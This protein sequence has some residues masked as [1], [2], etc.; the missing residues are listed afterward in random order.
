ML[1][2]VAYQCMDLVEELDEASNVAV[3]AAVGGRSAKQRRR[4]SS[5]GRRRRR[6]GGD[7]LYDSCL[8]KICAKFPSLADLRMMRMDLTKSLNK[9]W[10]LCIKTISWI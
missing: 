10:V 3:V 2:G 8:V 4:V 5:G 1:V 9:N 6:E 7:L